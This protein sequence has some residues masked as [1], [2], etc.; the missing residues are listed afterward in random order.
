MFIDDGSLIEWQIYYSEHQ[1]NDMCV[2][3]CVGEENA[4]GAENSRSSRSIT[5]FYDKGQQSVL[6]QRNYIRLWWENPFAALTRLC[7]VTS[8]QQLCFYTQT[9]MA[10][11]SFYGITL[12]IV[13]VHR[14]FAVVLSFFLFSY[15]VYERSIKTNGMITVGS[16]RQV[17][18]RIVWWYV[19][20]YIALVLLFPFSNASL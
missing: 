13:V 9:A 7:T 8:V 14:E 18:S 17:G 3:V 12:R 20:V 10:S 1:Y 4:V 16:T 11:I 19:Y 15:A 2:C 6:C 5:T